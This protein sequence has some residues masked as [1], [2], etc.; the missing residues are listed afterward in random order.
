MT[1]YHL[2]PPEFPI[3]HNHQL[4]TL[5]WRSF[6]GHGRAR[7]F[8]F[9]DHHGG[10][11]IQN[12]QQHTFVNMLPWT[13]ACLNATINSET[14]NPQPAIGSDRFSQTRRN[15]QVD[16]N[17]SGFGPPSGSGSRFWFGL[18]LNWPVF[19]VQTWTAGRLS[20]LVANIVLKGTDNLHFH[21]VCGVEINIITGKRYHMLSK[22]PTSH[23]ASDSGC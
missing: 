17:W 13:V 10:Q 22:N 15:P 20:R 19:V 21:F 6:S 11:Y 2:S 4:L 18:E 7:V 1:V 14:W 5:H 12:S 8:V 16:G 9:S 3:I 23:C